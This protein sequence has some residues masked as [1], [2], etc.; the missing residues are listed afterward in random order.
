MRRLSSV[1]A[2]FPCY[3]DGGT[4]ASMVLSAKAALE[5]LSDDFE[6][7]VVNDGSTDYSGVVLEQIS[8]LLPQLRLIT[9]PLNGG[10]GAALRSGF[11]AAGKDY[12]FYTDGDAQYDPQE[13][14]S[15]AEFLT[16]D[17]DVVNGYKISRSD[18]L[19]RRLVGG[20]YRLVMRRLFGLAVRDVDCDFRLMR[21]EALAGI[22]L[23]VDSGA[24]CVELVKKL[25]Y[26]GARFVD[27]PVHHYHR[28]Y[29]RS[30]FFRAKRIARTVSDLARLWWRLEIRREGRGIS[31]VPSA[32]GE[33]KANNTTD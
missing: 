28:A 17:R 31:V 16:E 22:T 6:I 2:I 26:A 4:I 19:H 10:Y 7:I 21:R 5:K 29:G 13:L 3:N 24:I 25:Q 32:P 23:A 14:L 8:A 11:A 30:Q 1:S 33:T 18:P 15:L 12:I 20:A 9:H 27:V